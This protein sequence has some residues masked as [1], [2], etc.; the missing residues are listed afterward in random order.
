MPHSADVS[1]KSERMFIQEGEGGAHS[2]PPAPFLKIV[3]V[4]SSIMPWLIIAGLLGPGCSSSRRLSAVRYSRRSW[5]GAII[6]TGWPYW[7]IAS[8]WPDQ[9]ARSW[10]SAR[11][12]RLPV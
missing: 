3:K 8:C 11:M 2:R 10:P 9:A 5:K 7:V 12:A 6:T 4:V 1:L